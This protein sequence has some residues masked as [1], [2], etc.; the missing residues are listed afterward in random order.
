[1][2]EHVQILFVHYSVELVVTAVAVALVS[3][4]HG[5]GRHHERR[6]SQTSDRQLIR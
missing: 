3:V 6:T 5:Y 1:M 4:I 2:L